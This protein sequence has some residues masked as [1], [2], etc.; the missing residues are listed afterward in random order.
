MHYACRLAEENGFIKQFETRSDEAYT[1][2]EHQRGES[3]LRR[4]PSPEEQS[5]EVDGRMSQGLWNGFCV[6][7]RAAA[8][9]GGLAVGFV[10]GADGMNASATVENSDKLDVLYLLGA[11]E[12]DMSQV[13]AKFVVYQGHH[14]D[15]GAHRA[16]VVLPGATYMEKSCTYVNTEGRAQ[17]CAQIATPPGMAKPDYQIILDLADALGVSLGYYKLDALREKLADFLGPIGVRVAAPWH[18]YNDFGQIIP[19]PLEVKKV[20]FHTTDVVS[21]ASPT[22][23][24]CAAEAI[25][26]KMATSC[27]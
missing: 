26:R 13:S 3:V 8:R 18:S 21:R 6:L 10:P 4:T 22:M 16:D 2:N 5:D 23:L 7:H 17:R 14:G 9:V 24:A 11:D 12:I 20:N 1:R 25:R 15:N 19:S 27:S